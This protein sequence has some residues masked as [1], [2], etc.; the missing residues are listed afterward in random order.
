MPHSQRR[1]VQEHPRSGKSHHLPDLLSHLRFIAVHPAVAAERL[2]FHKRTFLAAEHGVFGEF[3]AG[4]AH[5]A[6]LPVIFSVVFPTVQTDH[7]LHH[8]RLFLP[9][10]FHIS[11]C[12]TSASGRL[13]CPA[14][15]VLILVK[16]YTYLKMTRKTMTTL[17]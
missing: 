1:V 5:P 2:F 13:F 14:G 4:R 10:L 3:P 16:K 7:L 17:P 12:H 11:V 6:C 8:V 15:T 9:L